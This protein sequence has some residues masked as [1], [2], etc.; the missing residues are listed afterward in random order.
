MARPHQVFKY[1]AVRIFVQASEEVLLHVH[2]SVEGGHG[3]RFTELCDV[4]QRD[5]HQS[6]DNFSFLWGL[7]ILLV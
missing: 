7:G 2:H 4:I 6:T 1:G 5:V 3:Y